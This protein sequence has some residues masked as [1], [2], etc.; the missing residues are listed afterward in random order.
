[1]VDQRFKKV[2]TDP[3]FIKA[4]KDAHKIAIDDRFKHMLQS[5]EFDSKGILYFLSKHK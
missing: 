2:H 5:S 3:R 4:K 1:M